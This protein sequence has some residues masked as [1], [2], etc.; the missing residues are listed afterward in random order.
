[1][2][3]DAVSLLIA[4]E[5]HGGTLNKHDGTLYL[6]HPIRVAEHAALQAQGTDLDPVLCK[7]IGYLHDTVEDT[8]L[9]LAMLH[10]R[11]LEAD[12]PTAC[13]Q[14]I[15]DGV[16]AMTKV[17]TE[18]SDYY[19]KVKRN[20]YA[21]HVKVSDLTDN[22]RRNHLILDDEKRLKMAKKYS[23]AFDILSY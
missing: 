12:V 17:E 19:A 4:A 18:N 22:Y 13:I 21:R 2:K 15:L 20:P 10:T 6:L 9:T 14:I 1:M 8:A 16:D 3:T 7:A 11:L 5:Y 23:L